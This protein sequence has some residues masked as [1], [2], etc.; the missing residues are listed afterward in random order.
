QGSSFAAALVA[1]VA[2]LVKQQNPSMTPAQIKGAIVGTAYDQIADYDNFG[3]VVK[4]D[5]VSVGAGLVDAEWSL[6]TNITVSPVSVSFAPVGNTQPS[7]ILTVSNLGNSPVTLQAA[8]YPDGS[9]PGRLTVSPGS[10]TIGAKSSREI[11]VSLSTR[12]SRAFAEGRIYLTGGAVEVQIPYLYVV[13][14]G[15][16]ADLVP[17]YGD[18]FA[19][20]ANGEILRPALAVRVIDGYGMPVA[21]EPIQFNALS[22]GQITSQSQSTDYLGIA[23]AGILLGPDPGP[24]SFSAKVRDL[25]I[26]YTGRARRSPTIP[27]DGVTNAASRETGAGL[28]PGSY[29]AIAGSG[30]SEASKTRSTPY[31][32]LSLAGVSLSFDVPN[33]HVRVPGRLHSVS[34]S[35]IIAQI[36]WE[37]QG[38]ASAQIK[39]S[40][41]DTSSAVYTLPLAAYSPAGFEVDD[42]GGRIFDARHAADSTPVTS[43]S[44][45]GSGEALL[46]AVN[47]LGPLD[48]QPPSGEP[49]PADPAPTVTAPVTVTIGG[50]PAEVKTKTLAAGAVARYQL[51]V[52][53]GAGTPSGLQP[54]IVTA[55]GVSSK[56]VKLPMQ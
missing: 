15:V 6:S 4:A 49:A 52:I 19:F 50:V 27:T 30:L 31:L 22:G 36:P 17:I 16:P 10:F 39:V 43:A 44:P 20:D 47:G 51:R 9:D 35:L 55:G 40:I 56:P 42:A 1:G 29:I 23:D 37:L 32:P 34:D 14:D 12:P 38:L 45:A 25:E 28:A 48:H 11:T 46:L 8:V 2:A 7:Q 33:S 18:N 24:Q 54:V 41:G 21:N 5:V 13:G 3:D 53:A 26:F